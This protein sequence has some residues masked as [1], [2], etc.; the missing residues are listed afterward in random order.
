MKVVEKVKRLN[1]VSYE[2]ILQGD[3]FFYEG[4]YFI[5]I[6]EDGDGTALDLK[7]GERTDF[8]GKEDVTPVEAEVH[9]LG[10]KQ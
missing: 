6:D 1:P 3:C 4:D 2:D 8:D 10:N 9:I 7:T 5:K